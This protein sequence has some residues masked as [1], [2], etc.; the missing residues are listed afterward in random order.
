M[1]DIA[2]ISVYISRKDL[3]SDSPTQSDETMQRMSNC[4]VNVSIP[5]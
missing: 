3:K 2:E 4:L 5:V 1:V